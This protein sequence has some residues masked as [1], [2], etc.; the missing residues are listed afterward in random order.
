MYG[1]QTRH[2]ERIHDWEDLHKQTI[3]AVVHAS[4][5][6][7]VITGSYDQTVKVSSHCRAVSAWPSQGSLPWARHALVLFSFLLQ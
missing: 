7:H 6:N 4:G 3:T 5:S 2:G 1:F